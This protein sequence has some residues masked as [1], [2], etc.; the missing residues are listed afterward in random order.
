M[1]TSNDLAVIQARLA[2][3]LDTAVS[4]IIVIDDQGKMLVY[5]KACEAMFG[6]T[7]MEAIGQ[8][9]NMLMAP[10]DRQAHDRYVGQ[11][12]QT[13]EK[14]IIGIGRAV[15]GRHKDGTIFPL[16]LAVGDA[17]TPG[18]RQFIGILRDLRPQRAAEQRLKELQDQLIHLARVSALDEMGAALAHELNQPLTALMLYMQAG[19]RALDKVPP[20]DTDLATVREILGKATREAERAGEIVSRMRRFVEKRDARRKPVSLARI[21]SEAIEFAAIGRISNGVRWRQD[22][23]AGGCEIIA[24]PVQIQQIIVNLVRNALE[25]MEGLEDR[26][27]STRLYQE[28]DMIVYSIRDTGAGIEPKILPDLFRA[29]ATSKQT[30]M[31][32]GLAISRSIAQNHGGDLTVDAGGD[33]VG[34]CFTLSLPAAPCQQSVP[35]P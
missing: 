12:L 19:E 5:N 15:E 2:S 35:S 3:V 18:G 11:Y 14:K 16:D 28:G 22:I 7:A 23:D 33:G 30:G 29:F 4:G 21:V 13:G 24:D 9:V 26:R 8:S 17:A 31:G 20:P 1:N 6:Y 25:A 34:A 32:L 10:R 27:I